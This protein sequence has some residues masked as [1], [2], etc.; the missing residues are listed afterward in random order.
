MKT[1]NFTIGDLDVEIKVTETPTTARPT[2]VSTSRCA[3]PRVPCEPDGIAVQVDKP[4]RRDYCSSYAFERDMDKF[5]NLVR[6]AKACTWPTRG[7]IEETRPW[8]TPCAAPAVEPC[9]P[10]R[11]VRF[12]HGRVP[13]GSV[14]VGYFNGEPVFDR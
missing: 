5:E 3:S 13:L 9:R 8:P 14:V 7:R 1:L 10:Q 12:A 4:Q 6:A 11:E 2:R